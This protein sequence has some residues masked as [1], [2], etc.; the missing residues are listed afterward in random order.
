MGERGVVLDAGEPLFLDGGDEL[1]VDDSAAE[2][3]P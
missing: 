1:T 3:S 2:A